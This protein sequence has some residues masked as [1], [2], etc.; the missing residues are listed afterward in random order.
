MVLLLTSQFKQDFYL[1]QTYNYGIIQ[2]FLQNH[3]LKKLCETGRLFIESGHRAYD[4]NRLGFLKFNESLARIK[5]RLDL[6]NSKIS[7]ETHL[8]A[9]DERI[10][11]EDIIV[12][13]SNGNYVTGETIGCFNP[14]HFDRIKTLEQ[15][16]NEQIHETDK[17]LLVQA[18]FDKGIVAD[19]DLSEKIGWKFEQTTTPKPKVIIKEEKKSEIRKELYGKMLFKYGD[20]QVSSFS[21]Q[22]YSVD[23]KNRTLHLRSPDR[24][25]EFLVQ[26]ESMDFA[27][28]PARLAGSCNFRIRRDQF[29]SVIREMIDRNWEVE[30]Q[31]RKVESALNADF[32]VTSGVTGLTWK[33][34]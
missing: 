33:A 10:P 32:S 1:D 28:V 14:E 34:M 16:G 29:V 31:G 9:G 6:Q 24:E 26:T 8:Q 19:I 30:A 23:R 25:S 17:D 18:L 22:K 5:T 3:V 13:W 2:P 20:S 12:F 7:F 11:V 21:S 27:S 15:L 4:I